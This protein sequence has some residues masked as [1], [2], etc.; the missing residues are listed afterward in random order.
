MILLAS[1]Q[2]P[3]LEK[4]LLWCEETHESWFDVPKPVLEL[5]KCISS[6]SPVCSY[7]PVSPVFLSSI[8]TIENNQ[9]QVGIEIN[10]MNCI[11]NEAPII[12]EAIKAV[13]NGPL[14]RQW[15]DLFA[16]LKEI[17]ENTFLLPPHSLPPVSSE[18]ESGQLSFFPNWPTLCLRGRYTLDKTE[19]KRKESP[20][21]EKNKKCSLLP[22]LFTV[23]CEHGMI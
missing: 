23:Y 15:S 17:T 1:K 9:R 19:K 13:K 3:T 5:I 2:L 4:F 22:G 14:P 7:F 20:M 21:C 8:T 18:T 6:T 12:Y 16:N 10:A 11:Q